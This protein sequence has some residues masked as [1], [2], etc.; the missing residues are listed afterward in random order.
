V[1]IPGET[2]IPGGNDK[3]IELVVVPVPLFGARER[4]RGFNQA[5]VLAE[6]MLRQMKRL[7]PAWRLRL[8]SRALLRVKDTRAL[9]RLSPRQRRAAL[10]GAF[11]MANAEAVSGREVLLL[12]DIMT[13]GATAN[14]CA[15]VLLRGGAAKVWVVT[16]AKA[17]PESVRSVAEPDG[18]ALWSAGAAGANRVLEPD[19][20]RRVSF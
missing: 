18:A 9:Y 12:D 19:I 10:R 5:T 15:R 17:Q 16:A 6:A 11:R 3:K 8:E 1:P 13:T 4:E 7:R 20:G 14:E 2:Q